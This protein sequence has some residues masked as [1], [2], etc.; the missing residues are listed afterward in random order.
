M[1]ETGT[2]RDRLSR[3]RDDNLV[4]EAAEAAGLDERG[5]ESLEGLAAGLQSLP[6]AEASALLLRELDGLTYEQIAQ[7][8]GVTSA[9]AR[10]VVYRARLGLQGNPAPLTPHCDEVRVAMSK[11][12]TSVRD[13]RSITAHLERCEVCSEFADQLEERPQQLKTLFGETGEFDA[14]E[15]GGGAAAG[16]AVGAAAGAAGGAAASENGITDAIVVPDDELEE[17]GAA[18]AIGG[19]SAAAARASQRARERASGRGDGQRAR[20]GAFVPL[21]LLFVLIGGGVALAIA[22]SSGGGKSHKAASS[23]TSTVNKPAVPPAQKPSTPAKHAPK[24]KQAHK[25]VKKHKAR[26]PAAKKKGTGK[27]N[28]GTAVA[29]GTGAASGTASGKSGSGAGTG[30]T[31]STAGATSSGGTS[32]GP[33]ETRGVTTLPAGSAAAA[34]YTTH[35]TSVEREVSGGGLP[36]TGLQLGIVIAAALLLVGV[37]LVLRGLTLPRT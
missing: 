34:G 13:R 36:S 21:L 11:A 20:R 29:A 31:G 5:K 17:A 30:Q 10:Q 2:S 33:E 4:T 7:A 37:G 25:A 27:N 22:L 19:E 6:P 26:P 32:T 16:A 24:P 8:A 23:T 35:G 12:E 18:G 9:G 3:L 14:L 15:L 28:G 1:S